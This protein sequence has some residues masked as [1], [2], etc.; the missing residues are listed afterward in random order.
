MLG[1]FRGRDSIMG[2][3]NAAGLLKFKV[4]RGVNLAIRDMGRRS[5]D[6]Y[7]IL[8][9]GRQVCAASPLSHPVSDHPKT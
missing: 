2:V 3:K 8:T 6:P 4:I 7:V 9:W 1:C 5:S